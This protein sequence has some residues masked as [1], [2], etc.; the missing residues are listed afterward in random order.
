[1]NTLPA[2]M[3][4]QLEIERKVMK[5]IFFHKDT[6]HNI[7]YTSVIIFIAH[8]FC[9]TNTPTH[10]KIHKA[11]ETDMC[12]KIYNDKNSNLQNLGEGSLHHRIF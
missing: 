12:I 7:Y 6:L 4:I 11:R 1:M 3:K 5:I 9:V 2:E 8:S 10:L